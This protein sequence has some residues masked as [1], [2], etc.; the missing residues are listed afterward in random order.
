MPRGGNWNRHEGTCVRPWGNS[1]RTALLCVSMVLCTATSAA[2]P[3][4]RLL[5]DPGTAEVA[6]ELPAHTPMSADGEAFTLGPGSW[7]VAARSV[8][9]ATQRWRIFPKTFRLGEES[10]AEAYLAEWRAQGYT[11]ELITLGRRHETASGAFLDNRIHWVALGHRPTEAAARELVETLKTQGAWAWIRPERTAPGSGTVA[12]LDAAGEARVEVPLPMTLDAQTPIAVTRGGTRREYRGVVSIEA[13][14]NGQLEVYLRVPFEDYLSGVLPGEMPANWPMEALKAQAVAARSDTMAHLGLKHELEGYDF[15]DS[16]ANRVYAGH[17]ARHERTDAAVRETAGV[18]IAQGTRIVP[19]VF[20]S[21]A[22]GWTAANDTAWA[23]PAD[24]ALRP[25]GDFP[26]G[27]NPAPGGPVAYG[28]DRWL[29]SRPPAHSSGDDRFYRWRETRTQAEL[30]R[31]VNA[32]HAVGT[33]Q[34]IELGSRASCGRLESVRV[35]GST[36]TVTIR[37]ELP[38]RLAFGGLPS[39]MF[40]LRQAD[41]VYTFIG[42]GRGHG[43]GL[44]QHG[45]N[46]MAQAGHTYEAIVAHYFTGIELQRVRE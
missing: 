24:S 27:A 32:R 11:P 41:R 16:E 34:R 2:M 7:R 20:C 42:G 37:K 31:Q 4:L 26:A 22:G 1:V 3:S 43:V 38:I 9:P 40:I 15:D 14:V 17:G 10:A 23:S 35:V 29:T 39:A 8:Q 5:I 13:G 30:T 6:I 19:A 46:G 33:V 25:V 21:N 12:L 28:I 18:V 45:A 44:C 36:D